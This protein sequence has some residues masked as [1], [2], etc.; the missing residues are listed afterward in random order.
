MKRKP[1]RK[2]SDKQRR[3]NVELRRIKR[4]MPGVCAICGRTCQGELSHI[5]PRSLFPEYITERWNLQI[6]CHDCH[7]KYDNDVIFRQTQRE[8]FEKVKQHDE[9]AARRYFRIYE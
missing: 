2:V 3:I 7:Y 6:L 1:M 5:L 8:I 9:H 4:E